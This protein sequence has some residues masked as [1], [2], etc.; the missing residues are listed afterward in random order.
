MRLDSR[1]DFERMILLAPPYAAHAASFDSLEVDPSH[2]KFFLAEAQRL[3]GRVYLEDGAICQGELS[4]DGRL[5]HPQDARGWHLLLVNSRDSVLGAV[6]YVPL[7]GNVSFFN[8]SVARSA[9]AYSREW[10]FRLRR[11]VDDEREKARRRRMGYAEVGGLVLSEELRHSTAA[12]KLLLNVYALMRFLGGALAI[13]TATVR[14]HSSSIL[15][16][17]GGN[18]LSTDG[19]ELPSYYDAQY[20]CDMEILG[21]DSDSPAS[22]YEERIYE[23]QHQL[24]EVPVFCT[25]AVP[26]FA[27]Q[28]QYERVEAF[29]AR[30]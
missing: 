29:V 25:A 3:R 6:R 30:A 2:Y 20:E 23:Y 15:R 21:F 27:P 17:M 28:Y 10:G 16:R 4:P 11:A 19:G 7:E 14:H 12:V 1:F 8:L 9:L 22:K 13:A 24:L 18:S 5:V 26:R